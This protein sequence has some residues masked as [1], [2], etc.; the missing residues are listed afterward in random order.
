MQ[1]APF[2]FYL[3]CAI[4]AALASRGGPKHWYGRALVV[5]VLFFNGVCA[6]IPA[7]F[8][9]GLNLI[10]EFVLFE[11]AAVSS[12]LVHG[13]MAMF[14]ALMFISVIS[15]AISTSQ[16]LSLWPFGNYEVVVN[17][18]FLAE[19]AVVGRRGI[20]NVVGRIYDVVRG[21]G[22]LR[23]AMDNRSVRRDGLVAPRSNRAERSDRSA[24]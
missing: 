10:S 5:N 13:R 6:M 4:G 9:P 23:H 12:V 24:R 3:A 17:V 19:C 22:V 15:I 18:L 2:L 20:A 7:D 21:G 14:L 16:A 8:G 11:V 1:I